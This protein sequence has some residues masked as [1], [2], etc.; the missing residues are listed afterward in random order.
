MSKT[1]LDFLNLRQECETHLRQGQFIDAQKI[2]T[3]IPSSQIPRHHAAA[4][5]S[6]ARRSHLW[7]L[8]LKWLHPIVRP[9][10]ESDRSASAQECIEYAL[11]LQKAGA[12]NES[13]D[14]LESVSGSEDPKVFLSKAY[15]RMAQWDYASAEMNLSQYLQSS[16]LTEYERFIGQVN[17]VASLVVQGDSRASQQLL[18]LE[19]SLKKTPYKLLLSNCLEI[20]A[21]YSVF[22][23]DWDNAK[24]KLKQAQTLVDQEKNLD[25]LFIEKWKVIV[26]A[27]ESKDLKPLTEFRP[28]ALS[29][30]HWETLRDLDYYQF[31]IHPESQWANWVYY[32]TPHR[33][34]RKRMEKSHTFPDQQWVFRSANAKEQLDP[35]F[36]GD[37]EGDLSHRCFVLLLRDFYRPLRTGEAFNVL[38]PQEYF[39][40]DSSPN[41]VHKTINRTRN[42][43]EKLNLPFLL[44]ESD[45]SYS[46]R[47]PENY[48][49]LGRKK[50][51]NF[52]ETHF[53]LQ[54]FQTL[55]N[56]EF[57]AE[58]LSKLLGQS[59][60]MTQRI[61]KRAVEEGT[62]IKLGSGRF[63]AY[64]LAG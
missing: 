28:K 63:T 35:W 14:L 56:S 19:S 3:S 33:D 55:E 64:K 61:V 32:G 1:A 40:P 59:Q 6:L 20:S 25:A 7:K 4:L 12:L 11:A 41:R 49:L 5:A 31:L 53:L 22:M 13:E 57:N 62:L 17:L 54:R 38:F 34:F 44:S 39:N 15:V 43:L 52:E 50:L 21:Q 2:L 8:S 48:Q 42:W 10:V 24:E 37:G 23:N 60:S 46:L 36:P 26:S 30:G 58:E 18:E 9:A 27:M 51:L 47:I 45:G 29:L 16:Q